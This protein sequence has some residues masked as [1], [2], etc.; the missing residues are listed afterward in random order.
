MVLTYIKSK[1]GNAYDRFF[2]ERVHAFTYQYPYIVGPYSAGMFILIRRKKFN[3]LGGFN[4]KMVLGDDWE[5]TRMI[6]RK[7]FDVAETFIWTTNRR[8]QSHGYLKTT[9][10]Y[11]KVALSK[12]FR[13]KDNRNYV[14]VEF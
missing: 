8:F 4:E 7:K 10:K 1:D 13:Q 2:W 3:V 9:V 6:S 14:H 11:L 12:D 5:L